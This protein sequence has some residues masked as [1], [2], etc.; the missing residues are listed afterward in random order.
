MLKRAADESL[1]PFL[2][3]ACSTGPSSG[4]VATWLSLHTYPISE[5]YGWFDVLIFF[6]TLFNLS[7]FS[8][9]SLSLHVE[10]L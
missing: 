9:L 6:K 5:H 8:V 2:V 7:H 4:G 3:N 10:N 1:S